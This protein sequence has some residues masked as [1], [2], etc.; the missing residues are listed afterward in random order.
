LFIGGGNR[1]AMK[2]REKTNRRGDPFSRSCMGSFL[3][4][5]RQVRPDQSLLTL[6]ELC[7]K[8]LG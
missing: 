3:I 6:A 5:E 1:E 2:R 4:E 7:D 8:V